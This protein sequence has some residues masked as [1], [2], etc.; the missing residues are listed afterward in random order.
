LYKPVNKIQE[1]YF[2]NLT[3]LSENRG[4]PAS[5]VDAPAPPITGSSFHCDKAS[6]AKPE[7]HRGLHS[8][9]F[10]FC[11][12]WRMK[13]WLFG[14]FIFGKNPDNTA[15]TFDNKDDIYESVD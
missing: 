11:T 8:W 1:R 4:L 12:M 13:I 10:L 5:G 7:K 9:L 14:G 3:Q 2:R 6:L 15:A